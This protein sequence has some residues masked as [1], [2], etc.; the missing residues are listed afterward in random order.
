VGW[1][2]DVLH[3]REVAVMARKKDLAG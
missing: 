1:A 2:I 3:P